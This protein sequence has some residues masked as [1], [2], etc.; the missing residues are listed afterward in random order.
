LRR[1]KNS[2][3]ISE[4]RIKLVADDL[5]F[6]YASSPAPENSA[7]EARNCLG[8][9]RFSSVRRSA[10]R[11]LII[12]GGQYVWLIDGPG[13]NYGTAEVEERCRPILDLFKRPR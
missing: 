7:Q 10:S 11:G 12:R 3:V 4:A 2:F 5:L 8:P 1:G 6:Y 13:V 9:M